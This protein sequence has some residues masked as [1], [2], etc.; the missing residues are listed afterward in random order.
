VTIGEKPSV[1]CVDNQSEDTLMNKPMNTIAPALLFALAASPLAAQ[2][3]GQNAPDPSA[4]FMQELDTNRDGNV[5][6][7]EFMKPTQDGFREMDKNGDGLLT[8]PEVDAYAKEMQQRM[9]Q[10][11][12][13]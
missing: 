11:H 12:Q 9:Q 10:Q 4:Q 2:Q 13:Q 7:E 3:Q 1:S 8:K 5:T 6:L